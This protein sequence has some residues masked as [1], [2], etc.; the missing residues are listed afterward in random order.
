MHVNPSILEILEDPTEARLQSRG[1][2]ASLGAGAFSLA[3]LQASIPT[4]RMDQTR[5]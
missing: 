1:I 2:S 4:P 5:R 3:V